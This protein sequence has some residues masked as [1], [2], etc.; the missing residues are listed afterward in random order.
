MNQRWYRNLVS[1][2]AEGPAAAVIRMILLVMSGFYALAV[3][4]RNNLYDGRI[5]KS[6]KVN[7]PVISVGNITTGG[8]GKTPL[9][10]WLAGLVNKLEL[11]C[12][13]LTRGY[14][15]KRGKFTDEPAILVKSCQNAQVVVNSDRTAGAQ[16]AVFH[17]KSNLLVMDDG[18]QHRK[19]GRDIDI[20]AIDATC[21][22]GYGRMLPAGLLREPLSSIKRADIVVVTR[23]D[24]VS[25]EIVDGIEKKIQD[26][27]PDIIVARSIHSNTHAVM[28]KGEVIELEELKKKRIFAFCGIGNP[29]AFLD[30]IN[31]LGLDL[32]GSKIFND[33][34]NFSAR[35][36]EKIYKEAVDAQAELVLATQKDWI[37]TAL[38]FQRH[39]D[40]MFAYLAVE[41]EFT[42]NGDKIESLIKD[43]TVKDGKDV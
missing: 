14:K 23:S 13:V 31:G 24:Q 41:L 26:V 42:K 29:E 6:N 43:L 40:I 20:L 5:L 34:Y 10:I 27:K 32:A 33:H 39:R 36:V 15:A 19:L 1:G 16:K 30:R 4:V 25:E 28:V 37:K 38:P 17:H 8:T 35:D 7:V 3:F 12:G 22:F 18:F 9:V 21:P 11:R 2:K